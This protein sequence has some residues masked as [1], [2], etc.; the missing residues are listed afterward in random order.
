MR[1][2]LFELTSPVIERQDPLFSRV[3]EI[4]T[5]PTLPA[6]AIVSHSLDYQSAVGLHDHIGNVHT[7]IFKDTVRIKSVPARL[8]TES[9]RAIITIQY[10]GIRDHSLLFPS[11]ENADLKIRLGEFAEEAENAYANGSWMSF[12]VMAI[13]AIEGLLSDAFGEPI[14][15]WDKRDVRGDLA[16]LIL[17]AIEKGA[18]DANEGA[19]L[20]GARK[21]RNRIH[22]GRFSEPLAN[23]SS[24]TD[25]YVLY[26]RL[27]K[28]NWD[29]I[30]SSCK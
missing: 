10:A 21:V 30:K 26:D 20:D 14:K 28:K 8:P 27:L 23:R 22:S 7:D 25:M 17:Y 18:L 29:Q 4:Y 2:A 9:R 15:A 16:R 5:I 6:Y 3:D 1:T 11:V 13:S 12:T 19:L 24:A